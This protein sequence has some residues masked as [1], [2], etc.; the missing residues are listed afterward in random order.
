M[1]GKLAG[2]MPLPRYRWLC[3]HQLRLCI[4]LLQLSKLF[5]VFLMMGNVDGSPRPGGQSRGGRWSIAAPQLARN[6]NT[7]RWR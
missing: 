2:I 6:G 5:E 3:N 7:W 4:E 1:D